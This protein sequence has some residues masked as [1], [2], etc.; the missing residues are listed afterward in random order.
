[1][2]TAT[3]YLLVV[4]VAE[5]RTHGAVATGRVA[6]VVGRSPA[7]A[8]EALQRL[9]DRGLVTHEPYE[10]VALTDEGE[11]RAREAYET[12]TTLA[13]FFREVLGLEDYEREALAAVDTVD[14]AVAERI[15]AKL[16]PAAA[17]PDPREEPPAVLVEPPDSH[18]STAGR[19][20]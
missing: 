3:E 20:S 7:A 10:G 19:E 13:R 8:T 9:A 12:F 2:T 4:Y 17:P 15:A 11:A 5:R 18:D 14:T 16:L 6:A 1:V